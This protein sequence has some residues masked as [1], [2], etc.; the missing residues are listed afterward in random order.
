VI[1]TVG[2]VDDGS[3]QTDFLPLERQRGITIKSAVVSFDL[4]DITVNLID[5]PGH[6]DFIAEV[7]R[8]LNVLDGA[9]LV[10]SAVK[11]VQPQTRVLMRTLQRLHIPTIIFVNKIDRTGAQEEHLLRSIAERL[12]PAVMPMGSTDARGTRAARFLPFG[13]SDAAFTAGLVELLADQDEALLA[14]FVDGGTVSYGRLRADLAALTRRALVH[15]LYFGSAIT[16]VGVDALTAGI[17]EFLPAG[18]GDVAGAVEGTVFKVTRGSTGEKIAYV[19]MVSGTVHTRERVPFGR[20]QEGKVTAIRV[21]ER[22]SAVQRASLWA[23]QI[24][25]IWGLGAVRI[26]DTI[27]RAGTRAQ[28]HHFDPP[29]LEAAVVPARSMDKGTLHVALEQLAEADPLINL[30]QDD[31][32][33]EMYVSLYGEVQKEVIE[34]TLALEYGIEASFRE[35]AVICIERPTGIGEAVERMGKDSNPFLATLGMRIEPA[36]EG[37]G[38]SLRIEAELVS[39]PLFI[40]GSTEE[41]RRVMEEN[42]R[43]VLQQGLSGWQVE[44][45][46]VTITQCGYISPSSG[47]RDFRLLTPLVL[48]AALREAGTV[49][50]EPVQRF[51]LQIP[52]DSYGPAVSLLLR[53]E[54]IVRTTTVEGAMYTLEGQI[55]AARVHALQQQIPPVTSGEGLLEYTFDRYRRVSG[56][57]PTRPRWD[58]NPLDRKEYLMHVMRRV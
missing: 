27:G 44:D 29:L 6:P 42:V 37:A 11:G 28:G 35:T 39:L 34:A 54:A 43:T 12:T 56:P 41:F 49:V 2:S 25:Q 24:G 17:E 13:E 19:R 33:G 45:C 55:P 10:V 52:D 57:P 23:G 22:G 3:T 36:P 32:R 26:G 16:G 31:R 47:A 8:V 30:R 21:F 58:L 20:S 1:D 53:S 15:P 9:I 48:M 14:A 4:G 5:T 50:C 38:M 18:R 7:E 40:Y 51:R 46:T